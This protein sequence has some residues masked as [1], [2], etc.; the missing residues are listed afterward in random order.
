MNTQQPRKYFFSKNIAVLVMFVLFIPVSFAQQYAFDS[1]K[2]SFPYQVGTARYAGMGGALGALGTDVSCMA[3]NPAGLGMIRN[4]EFS[5][6]PALFIN[7][8]ESD[9]EGVKYSE[10]KFVF[11]FG[12]IAAVYSR[13]LNKEKTTGI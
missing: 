12:N 11:S 3:N 13:R 1:L 4:T 6:S 10:D 5:V 8:T 9:F 2:Y 7:F